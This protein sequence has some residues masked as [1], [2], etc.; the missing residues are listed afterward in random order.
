MHYSTSTFINDMFTIK[1]TPYLTPADLFGEG[2]CKAFAWPNWLHYL[3]DESKTWD[4]W[5]G[6]P[7]GTV[8]WTTRKGVDIW[9]A[10]RSAQS[11]VVVVSARRLQIGCPDRSSRCGC[12]DYTISS[13]FSMKYS[14]SQ[15]TITK[16][17]CNPLGLHL[18]R[19]SHV[20][21]NISK[22]NRFWNEFNLNKI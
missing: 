18:K 14:R 5:T 17:F 1:S 20:S 7:S 11:L 9:C 3:W 22:P 2:V 10:T 12:W 13:F 8:Q 19:I 6:C 15:F 21:K 4:P 16:C